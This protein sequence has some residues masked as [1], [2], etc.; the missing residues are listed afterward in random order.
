[1]NSNFQQ[2]LEH[3][4]INRFGTNHH[5]WTWN[6]V[7]QLTDLVTDKMYIQWRITQHL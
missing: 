1:M 4:N 2:W 6:D 7:I 3:Q 5:I